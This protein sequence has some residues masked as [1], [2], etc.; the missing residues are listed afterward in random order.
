M[1]IRAVK[2]T[3]NKIKKLK[4]ITWSLVQTD[5]VKYSVLREMECSIQEN[6]SSLSTT[7]SKNIDYIKKGVK[8]KNKEGN[9]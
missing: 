9:H 4:L 6:P 8:I 2:K 5:L 3:L 7:K 1:T